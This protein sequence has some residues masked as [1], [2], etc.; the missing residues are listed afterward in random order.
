M[1]NKNKIVNIGNLLD[2]LEFSLFS[3]LLPLIS[4]DILNIGNSS[5]TATLAY[6]LFYFGFLGRPLGAI[7]FGYI[8]DMFGRKRA[9]ILSL[10]GM[11]LATFSLSVVPKFTYAYIVIA[12]I[13]FVQGIFTGGE[14]ANATVYVI[15]DVTL[16]NKFRSAASL[17]ASGIWGASI[18]QILGIIALSDTFLALNWRVVFVLVSLVSMYVAI[19][20][21]YKIKDNKKEYQRLKYEDIKKYVYSRFVV[22]GI[23][24]GGIMN[25][26]FYL[27]YTFIGTYNSIIKNNFDLNSYSLSFVGSLLLGGFLIIWSRLSF[28]EKQNPTTIIKIALLG[29]IFLLYPM[30]LETYYG[31]FSFYSVFLLVLFVL[32]MQLFTLFVVINIPL[33]MPVSCRVLLS[34]FSISLGG[35][36]LGGASPYISSSLINFTGSEISPVFYFLCLMLIAFFIVSFWPL[37]GVGERNEEAFEYK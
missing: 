21:T 31:N 35:S 30:Y 14:Y 28:L 36:F 33:N 15:E 24:F 8:G 20:R 13:R 3:S 7:L 17:T 37:A 26:L 16:K 5:E 9:L 19:T 12:L 27:I 22:M 18:G 32:F 4:K 10:A 29:M 34:G 1:I 23:I 25:G 2:F 11:S 6:L